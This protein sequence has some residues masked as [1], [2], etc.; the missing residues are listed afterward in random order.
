M[1]PRRLKQILEGLTVRSLQRA[2]PGPSSFFSHVLCVVLRR[3]QEQMIGIHARRIVASVADEKARQNR[4]VMELI[5]YPMRVDRVSPASFV[6]H[7]ISVFEP[8]SLPFPALIGLPTRNLSPKSNFDGYSF[9]SQLGLLAARAVRVGG[10]WER[11]ADPSI[12]A[13]T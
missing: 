7:P 10:L 6:N 12:L 5:G 11:V 4:A 2:N 3:A 8:A 9:H 13:K 1:G